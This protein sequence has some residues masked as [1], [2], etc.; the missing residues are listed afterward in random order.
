MAFGANSVV[1]VNV[2]FGSIPQQPAYATEIS[3]KKSANTKPN[4]HI[5]FIMHQPAVFSFSLLNNKP[6]AIKITIIPKNTHSHSALISGLPGG[7]GSSLG[8]HAPMQ[9]FAA[10][11]ASTSLPLQA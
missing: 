7:I 2:W 6:A 3:A 5:D 10:S 11:P 9:Q 1:K 4:L 8:S